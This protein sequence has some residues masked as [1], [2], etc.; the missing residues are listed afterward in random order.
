MQG[1]GSSRPHL[2]R[3]FAEG[4]SP[5]ADAEV[6][7]RQ[8]LAERGEG[9]RLC[10]RRCGLLRKGLLKRPAEILKD[11]VRKKASPLTWLG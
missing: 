5:E 8:P 11:A 10:D 1:N 4:H 7:G 9:D 3:S 6:T 2:G